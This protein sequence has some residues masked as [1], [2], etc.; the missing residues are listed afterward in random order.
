MCG[1]ARSALSR[2]RGDGRHA[3]V[4]SGSDAVARRQAR[5]PAWMR[6]GAIANVALGAAPAGLGP[7]LRERWRAVEL[8]GEA[9]GVCVHAW[10]GRPRLGLVDAAVD[11]APNLSTRSQGPPGEGL[12]DGRWFLPGLAQPEQLELWPLYK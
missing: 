12:V 5:L 3:A 11:A 4:L 2:P 10:P 7:G 9:H 1:R 6:H 8:A